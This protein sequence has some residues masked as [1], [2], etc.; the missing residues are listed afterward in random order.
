M[1]ANSHLT[2][3]TGHFE[4]AL[5]P[6]VADF[7]IHTLYE[8]SVPC[9]DTKCGIRGRLADVESVLHSRATVKTW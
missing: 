1:E 6:P 8:K 2:T 5:A 9:Q 4:A 7:V 3:A